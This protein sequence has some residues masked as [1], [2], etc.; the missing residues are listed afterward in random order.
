MVVRE[1]AKSKRSGTLGA[2]HGTL[3]WP[4]QRDRFGGD[5]GVSESRMREIRTSSS[6]SGGWKRSLGGHYGTAGT[7]MFSPTSLRHTAFNLP[8]P[9][10]PLC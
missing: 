1:A 10:R 6:M 9:G 7:H 2:S 3:E 5:E 4:A 8:A